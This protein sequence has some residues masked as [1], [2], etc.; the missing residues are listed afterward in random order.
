MT[1]L[2]LET[3]HALQALRLLQ[4]L[5]TFS[6]NTQAKAALQDLPAPI[7][8][9][10]RKTG[11]LARE[12]GTVARG[13]LD[14]AQSFGVVDAQAAAL[15]NSVV[16]IASALPKALAGDLT[17]IAGIIGG[18][19]NIASQIMG[20]DKARNK[21]LSD[22]TRN[23]GRLTSE[24]GNL[25]LGVTGDTFTK[26]GAAL[27]AIVPNLKR[28]NID[29]KAFN[30][31]T[32]LQGLQAQGLSLADLEEV[33]KALGVNI[34]DSKGQLSIGAF[35]QLLEAIGLTEFGQFGSGF[36]DKLDSTT[37][38]FDINNVGAVDQ[39]RQLFGVGAGFSPALQGVF[40]ANDLGGTRGRLAGLFAQLQ[41][42]TLDAS[43][44]GGLTGTQF[45]D[46]IT[47]LI[48]R[49]DGLPG[50]TPGAPPAPPSLGD[51]GLPP[52]GG[53]VTP[54]VTLADVFRDY[55]A[56]AVPLFQ[57][58]LEAQLRIASATEA[59]A[60]NTAMTV[61]EL[62]GLRELMASG[63]FVDTLDR[64][65]ADRRRAAEISAGQSVTP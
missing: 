51:E 33:G 63:A 53:P 59:T 1:A 12:V 55:G 56:A 19:A 10:E 2:L 23:L 43:Q 61:D 8:Q 18:V 46:L 25:R 3:L 40:D 49:I 22:N 65:L 42:G 58:Q 36:T 35:K 11:D 13:A 48:G 34:K 60:D 37:R 16:N 52:A 54:V 7:E 17:S 5:N 41:A 28:D 20:G 15:L 45:L 32:I 24:V 50:N 27:G 57:S 21:L 62:R 44:F 14:L 9:S 47:D 64:A 39:I 38:G 6:H 31:G 30:L 26:V 29:N 4:V